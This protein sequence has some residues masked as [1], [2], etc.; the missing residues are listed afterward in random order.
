MRLPVYERRASV[1]PL[2]I[3]QVQPNPAL[4]DNGLAVSK[5]LEGV[6]GR[7]QEIQNGM[8]DARTLELFNKFKMDSQEYHENPDRGIYNTRFGYQAYGIYK[9]AD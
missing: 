2:S 4:S 1:L 3:P 6:F 7:I 5:N 9:E 8:E